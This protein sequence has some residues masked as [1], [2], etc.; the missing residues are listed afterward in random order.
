MSYATTAIADTNLPI[1]HEFYLTLIV[2]KTFSVM[3]SLFTWLS[4][5]YESIASENISHSS[6]VTNHLRVFLNV[7]RIIIPLSTVSHGLLIYHSCSLLSTLCCINGK[8]G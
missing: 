2:H 8:P 7:S 1:Y 3:V 6:D 5:I 4:I